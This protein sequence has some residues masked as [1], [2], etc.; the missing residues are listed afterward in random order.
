MHITTVNDT[1]EFNVTERINYKILILFSSIAALGGLLFGYDFSVISGGIELIRQFFR[2]GPFVEGF[3][4][5][6]LYLGCIISAALA[7]RISNRFGRKPILMLSALLFSISSIGTALSTHI[8]IFILFRF[9]GGLGVGLVSILSPMYIAEIS[10][11]K[12][13]G[14]LITLNQLAIVVAIF[15]TYFMNYAFLKMYG[16]LSWRW[17]LGVGVL[18]SLLF[19]FSLLIIPES[20]RWLFIAGRKSEAAD[21]WSRIGGQEFAN[22]NFDK[23]LS[24]EEL[25]RSNIYNFRL[26]FSGKIKK[27]LIIAILLSVFQ[28]LCGANNVFIYAPKIFHEA[29]YDRLNQLGLTIFIGFVNLVVTILAMI[30]VDKSGRRRLLLIGVGMLIFTYL[31]LGLLFRFNL[32]NN[33]ILLYLLLLS[34]FSYGISLAPVT[35]II[36]SEIFPN[37]IRSI[38]MSITVVCLWTSCFLLLQTFPAIINSLKPEYTFYLFAF[39][40]SVGWLFILLAIPETKGKSLEEI[41]KY[42]L[43]N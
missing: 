16:D 30:L 28:Q 23:L 39:I 35:W 31:S 20:P 24:L 18:P 5:A 12:I 27:I 1:Q 7:G 3:L 8:V 37:Q 38:G 22:Y 14:A 33:K 6:S 17:M 10:P 19:L 26:L 43:K 9:I 42:L 29:G 32:E 21:I 34:V 11:Q 40:C 4:V 36:I 2:V 15:I 13:R 25:N 41:E